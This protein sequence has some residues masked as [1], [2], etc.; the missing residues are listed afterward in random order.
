MEVLNTDLSYLS[1]NES[2]VIEPL[3]DFSQRD[4]SG[5]STKRIGGDHS[6]SFVA[7]DEVPCARFTIEP[8]D[9]LYHGGFKSELRDPFIAMPGDSIRYDLLLA[10]PEST[11]NENP[12]LVIAQWHDR[13]IDGVPAA[14]PPLALRLF[15]GKLIVSMFNDQVFN[16]DPDGKGLILGS[17]E[18]SVLRDLTSFRVEVKWEAGLDGQ[19]KIWLGGT[20]FADYHGPI[21][22]ENDYFGPYFK[23][24]AYTTHD[25]KNPLSVLYAKYNRDK[26]V[27]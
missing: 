5:F 9:T 17:L 10:I 6:L 2:L 26:I 23:F 25:F 12:Q 27:F 20:I 13:K 3:G 7:V 15:E 11:L 14:R 21:G 1:A 8:S 24:G 16:D 22:Y 19:V 4:L 18:A